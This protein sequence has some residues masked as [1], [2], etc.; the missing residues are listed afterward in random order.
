MTQVEPY[1]PVCFTKKLENIFSQK[2]YQSYVKLVKE[3]KNLSY[4][5]KYV[6]KKSLRHFPRPRKGKNTKWGQNLSHHD[7]PWNL[8]YQLSQLLVQTQLGYYH[9]IITDNH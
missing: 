5:Q 6:K 2:L 1:F 3:S 8:L 7:N 4:G 9:P